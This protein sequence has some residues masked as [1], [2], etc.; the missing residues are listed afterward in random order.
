MVGGMVRIGFNSLILCLLHLR[1]LW[2][3]VEGAD[4]SLE[5]ICGNN[6]VRVSLFFDQCAI[7]YCL[8][9]F[10]PKEDLSESDR[11]NFLLCGEG[12]LECVG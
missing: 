10:L 12:S 2:H 4:I 6:L 8:G 3:Q 5:A 7:A 11:R 1:P 9:G